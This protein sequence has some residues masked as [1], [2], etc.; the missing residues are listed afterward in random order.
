[1]LLRN[2][3]IFIYLLTTVILFATFEASIGLW[4]SFFGNALLLA[5]ITYYHIFT[6]KTYSPFLSTYIVFN[7]LFFLVA[8]IIQ[9]GVLAPLDMGVFEN[10]Y[11][12]N[13]LTFIKT[14][15]LIA[16][17]HVVFFLFY[18][19]L[20]G[21][22][23]GKAKRYQNST[24]PT[25]SLLRNNLI[26][27]IASI[28]LIAISIT[29]LLD[30]YLKSGWEASSYSP[31]YQLVF[32][33][34]FYTIP[35]AGIVMSKW[36]F[37]RK[38]ISTQTWILNLFICF[39]LF[40]LVL[41]V[42]NPLIEK[43]NALGPIYLMLLFLFYPR[44]FNSNVKT[45]L[46]LFLAMIVGFP[47][48]QVLTH[49]NY[50]LTEVISKPSLI[51]DVIDNGAFSK[52][53]MSLNYDAFSNIGVAMEIVQQNGFSYGY[54]ILS[55]LL[56]FIP[57]G[58]WAG[59]PDASG[60]VIGEHL[61][62]HYGFNFTNLSNPLVSEGYMNF[63]IPGLIVMAIALAVSI[64]YFSTW[65]RSNDILKKAVAFYF[66]IHL[67]F[68]LRGD[69]T[70]GYSYFIGTLIGLYFIPKAIIYLSNFIFDQKVWV[71]KKN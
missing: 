8:P 5:F 61:V 17:F 60:L 14:N 40:L 20:K 37:N 48:V 7:Y 43:R 46:I 16:V 71:S 35:L 11:P 62:D 1:M 36:I 58:I 69:F 54:Q 19:G 23:K 56:F 39:I 67:L 47:L 63:G 34:I 12:F 10:Y 51:L 57:R 22:I 24:T 50:E 4:L 2:L 26:I 33:K 42:K 66:A 55:A 38:G 9:A 29:F 64:I 27:I 45:S 21:Y 59:K 32:K 49:I 18:V 70:N 28:L 68:L 15:G 6:E 31:G 3:F 53:Y 13:E 41:I 30:E 65:L 44:I 25:S 52:G